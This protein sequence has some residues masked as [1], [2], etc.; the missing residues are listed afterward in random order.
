MAVSTEMIVRNKIGLH[1]RPAAAFVKMAAGFKSH[2][3]VE[4]LSRGTPAASAKSI[5]SVL[6]AA[7]RKDDMIRMVAEGEDEAAAIAALS[8][9]VETNFGEPE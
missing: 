9:L 7:V 5:L 3:T 4:N 2:I 1:A 8:G 6:S